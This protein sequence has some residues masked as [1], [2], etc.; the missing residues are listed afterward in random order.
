MRPSLRTLLITFISALIF[1][2]SSQAQIYLENG[3]QVCC[4][5]SLLNGNYLALGI[6]PAHLGRVLSVKR[7]SGFLQVGGSFYSHGLDLGQVLDLSF[8]DERIDPAL[9]QEIIDRYPPE[10]D[11]EYDGKLDLN[12]LSFSY[13]HPKYGGIAIQIQDQ[14]QSTAT[15]PN[16][17]L[18]IALLGP[19]APV[20]QNG[21]SQQALES[22]NGTRFSYAHTRRIRV[23]YGVK[24]LQVQEIKLYAGATYSRLFGIGHLNA[25]IEDQ[26]FSAI[27]SFSELYRLDY[28]NLNLQ[29][30]DD[31]RQLI[32]NAG[33]G[34]AFSLGLSLDITQKA[35]LSLSL[36]DVGSL[37]F[38]KN[39][40]RHEAS[41]QSIIDSIGSGI[42]ES[43][44]A[45]A[46]SVR[47][48]DLTDSE[49]GGEI[50]VILNT[51]A[52][53]GGTYRINKSLFANAEAIIPMRSSNLRVIDTEQATVIGALT[54]NPIPRVFY[55][56]AGTFYNPQFGWRIPVGVSVGLGPRAR[57]S[58]STGD[59]AT[60][61]GA[62]DPMASLS[63]SFLGQNY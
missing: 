8:G 9:K 5:D 6:N 14:F 23:G 55:L 45:G 28:Q 63:I 42:V 33:A 21:S 2:L 57:L 10:D 30:P 53:V 22:G 46:T 19:A 7:G 12:W 18:G 37:S 1:P 62:K 15:I 48:F 26:R 44:D 24:L 13:A 36:V 50:D 59:L 43:Y 40:A 41:V 38:T 51:H 29:N 27:S 31:Q 34:H 3:R 4:G 58:V 25:D 47:L 49:Y 54:W 56:T 39:V 61:L 16:E 52:R 17:F 32:S 35:N 60:F 11:F 20:F